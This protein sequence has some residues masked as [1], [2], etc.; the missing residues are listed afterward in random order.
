MITRRRVVAGSAGA[1]LLAGVGAS[2]FG[3]ED[4]ADEL[5]AL[6]GKRPL[7]KRSFR[8]PN[9]ETPLGDLRRQYTANDAFFVRYHLAS[10]PQVD[11]RAWRLRVEGSSI[12]QPLELS[13]ADLKRGFER[14]EL[15]AI[16]QC[17]G[18]RRGLF[19]PRAGGV[20]WTYGAMGNALWGGVR[21]RDVLN[22]AGVNADALEIVLDGADS[23]V[24][25]ATP[26]FV[27]SLPIDRALDEHT[28][29][30]FEMNGRPLPHWNG[31]PA[32]LVVPGWTAT[33][34]IKHLTSI[35]AEP[36]A[37][38]GFWMK[39][40]YRIPTGKFPGARFA[41]QENAETTP[42]TE[43]LINSLIT[44]HADGERLVR[45]RP[46]EVAGWAWDGS[47]GIST[48]EI[49]LDAGRSWRPAQLS[50]APGSYSWRGFRTALDTSKAGPLRI[51]V[52]ATGRNGARQPEQLT[53]NP[54][55]Y[56]HNIIQMLT[57]EVA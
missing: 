56:H 39:S 51:A 10:I 16:C 28:L 33:Y 8:P 29:I 27:K 13:L 37:F 15:A 52:R 54:S 50:E 48:V 2:A 36:K 24:L 20:Q 55:G 21:L 7:I 45:G 47:S 44:S 14:V 38:D 35:R 23:Q 49:S 19:T 17:S 3:A 41:S 40:A 30:A 32:R 25:P 26:D 6:P 46:A 12:K 22:R 11:E 43:I 34:W 42:I 31:A 4:G 1:L 9:Y 5:I 53:P 18:N 57:L